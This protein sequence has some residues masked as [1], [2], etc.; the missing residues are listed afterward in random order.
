VLVKI[1]DRTEFGSPST[2]SV[3]KHRG[4]WVGV[5]T[6]ALPNGV[7]G[8]VRES[9]ADVKRASTSQEIRVSLSRRQLSFVEG[10]RTVRTISVAIGRSGSET[11][12][13]TF[14]VTDK[15]S[16]SSF[17]PYYGCCVLAL[18][19]HQPHTPP[20]W[21]GGDRLAIHG[22]DSPGTVGTPASAGCLR[23]KDSDLRLLIK[24]VLLGTPVVIR[25]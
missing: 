5:T 6:T 14:A 22:T 4:G 21:K 19:G 11:P 7:L 12:T 1:A 13:G 10:R 23:A 17:G 16:G 24:D 20:G 9:T 3:V 8:W 15:L 25:P 18:S 2:L